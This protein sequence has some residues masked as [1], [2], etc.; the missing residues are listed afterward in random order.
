MP[1]SEAVNQLCSVPCTTPHHHITRYLQSRAVARTHPE[2][3][4][5]WRWC[6]V[7]S[8]PACC[9]P[10]L[11]SRSSGLPSHFSSAKP[12][13][14]NIEHQ[15]SRLKS[16]ANK[17][18]SLLPHHFTPQNDKLRT[19]CFRQYKMGKRDLTV[20]SR[21]HLD[22]AGVLLISCHGLRHPGWAVFL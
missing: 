2:T 17:G 4:C 20:H 6:W 22:I 5:R 3:A 11:Y 1:S 9:E 8:S 7:D 14:G 10:A 15:P 18:S 16:N 13:S 12:S 19:F 21:A